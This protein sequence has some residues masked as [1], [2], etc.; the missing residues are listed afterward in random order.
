MILVFMHQQKNNSGYNRETC[1]NNVNDNEE[2]VS[3]EDDDSS[4]NNYDNNEKGMSR[5][6]DAS[7]SDDPRCHQFYK[8]QNISENTGLGTRK[9]LRLCGI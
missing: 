2:S 7:S 9:S 4:G 1:G 5:E 8:M 6:D 3:H